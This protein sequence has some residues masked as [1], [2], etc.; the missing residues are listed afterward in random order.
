VYVFIDVLQMW[1][2]QISTTQIFFI[3]NCLCT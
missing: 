1:A 3:D 2:T